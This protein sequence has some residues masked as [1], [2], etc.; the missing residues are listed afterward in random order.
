[1][2]ETANTDASEPDNETAVDY[3]RRRVQSLTQPFELET[4]GE[5]FEH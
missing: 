3:M 1:M 5:P 2:I 4:D